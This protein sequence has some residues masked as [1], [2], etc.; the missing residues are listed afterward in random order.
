[1]RRRDFVAMVGA[2]ALA[3]PTLTQ[4]Q[5]LATPAIGFLSG[6]SFRGAH[7]PDLSN[8]LITGHQRWPECCSGS[9][10]PPRP[11]GCCGT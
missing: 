2:A 11:P 8:H 5:Q 4:A 3:S 6:G 1:M 7:A 9:R 10:S